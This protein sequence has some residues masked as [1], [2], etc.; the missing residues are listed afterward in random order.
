[1][2]N[3]Y[4][5]SRH[6]KQF[7]VKTFATAAPIDDATERAKN[8][9]WSDGDEIQYKDFAMDEI[10]ANIITCWLFLSKSSKEQQETF[11]K[12]L[13]L[14]NGLVLPQPWMKVG[15][16]FDNQPPNTKITLRALARNFSKPA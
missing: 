10:R 12:D 5:I 14:N 11:I 13:Q 8:H 6:N 16:W 7:L 15:V 1:M 4:L 9:S 2:Q 3:K